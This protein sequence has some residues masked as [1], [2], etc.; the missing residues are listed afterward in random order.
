MRSFGNLSMDRFCQPVEIRIERTNHDPILID[1][2]LLMQANKVTP[3]QGEKNAVPG[4]GERKHGNAATAWAGK[5]SL[6]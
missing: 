2:L 4:S 3:V 1:G 6:E 5:F